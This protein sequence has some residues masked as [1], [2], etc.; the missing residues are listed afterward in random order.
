MKKSVLAT[1]LCICALAG[2]G[3][4]ANNNSGDN[5]NTT[6]MIQDDQSLAANSQ[7]TTPNGPAPAEVPIHLPL[8]EY[9]AFAEIVDEQDRL[10]AF[11]HHTAL[12]SFNTHPQSL[13]IPSL[14]LIET[15]E[16]DDG[17]TYYLCWV[18]QMR[19]LSLAE[20][21]RSGAPYVDMSGD[22]NIRLIRFKIKDMFEWG[23]FE[24]KFPE[25]QCVEI[26]YT[27]DGE[28]IWGP[29]MFEGFPG[30]QERIQRIRGGDYEDYIRDILPAEIA[31]DY[32]AL[33]E[34][35]LEYYGFTLS[36]S[37]Q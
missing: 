11:L 25:F 3:C 14:R 36:N 21:I 27:A 8:P 33:L 9:E 5:S 2:A 17:D 18:A 30:N 28:N 37:N 35:Y 12:S 13:F 23:Y 10:D 29:D 6:S 1:F 7:P 22:M 16:S 34:T 26:I 31:L 32:Y 19:Y 4:N 20:T 15:W 24:F